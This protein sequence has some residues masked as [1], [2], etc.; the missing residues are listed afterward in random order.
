MVGQKAKFNQ[1]RNDLYWSIYDQEDGTIRWIGYDDRYWW[2]NVSTSDHFRNK[3]G[4]SG[5]I[6]RLDPETGTVGIEP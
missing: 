1:L 4:K 3:T 6:Y 2:D 5:R